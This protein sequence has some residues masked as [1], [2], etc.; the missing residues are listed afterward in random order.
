MTPQSKINPY[1]VTTEPLTTENVEYT[2]LLQLNTIVNKNIKNKLKE[3]HQ[4][5]INDHKTNQQLEQ[6]YDYR[7]NEYNINQ[8]QLNAEGYKQYKNINEWENN[9]ESEKH[10]NIREQNNSNETIILHK[11]ISD[12][13]IE[14]R[15]LFNPH[16]GNNIESKHENNVRIIYQN[17]NSIKPKNTNKWKSTLER[18]HYLKAVVIGLVETCVNWNVNKTRQIFKQIVGKQ[19]KKNS[20]TVSIIPNDNKNINLPGGSTTVTF[21]KMVDR[22]EKIIE[23]KD[24]MGRWTGATYRVGSSKKLN[25]ITAYRV[26]DAKITIHNSITTNC[27]QTQLLKNRN[28]Y[29]TKPR[30]QFILDFIDQFQENCNNNDEYTLLLI[31]ANES[32]RY[33]ERGGISDLIKKCNLIDIYQEFHSDD[34]EFPTHENGSRIIDYI[35]GTPNILEYITK[36]GYVRFNELFE[37]DHRGIFCDITPNIFEDNIVNENIIRKD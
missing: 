25:I 3:E 23:D 12:L 14:T 30:R 17:I 4:T 32:I 29:E 2:S 24:K 15:L 22:L 7:V 16:K 18:A 9:E 21:D 34:E 19:Y 33:P 11:N 8:E 36:I 6:N 13:S 1:K 5:L 27:Q 10:N 26:I 28:I 35:F 31:D 20:M 37:S